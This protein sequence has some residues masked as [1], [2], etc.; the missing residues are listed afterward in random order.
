[1]PDTY[2]VEPRAVTGRRVRRLRREGTIPANIY[3]RGIASTAV[4]L[5]FADARTMLHAHGH[6]VLIQVQVGGEPSPR[7]VVIRAVDSEPLTGALRHI[8]FY[9]V[10]LSRPITGD[11]PVVL[12]GEAPAVERHRGILVHTT[13]SV[14]V[15]AL[16][17]D[18]PERL[19]VS[20]EGLR[21][22]DEDVKV[23]DMVV[24]PGVRVLTDEEVTLAHIARPRLIEGEE[25]AVPEG[26]EAPEGAQAP[27]ERAPAAEAEGEEPAAER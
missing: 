17:S 12:V 25:E 15:E 14:Q 8:D 5:P 7:P 24:P 11:V 13:D 9:Q 16:P 6:N 22:F 23:R 4:Q 20:V 18:M 1:M 3:G 27:A 21:E 2:P 19:E 26:E 10:D